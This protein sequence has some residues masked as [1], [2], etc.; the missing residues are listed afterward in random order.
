MERLKFTPIVERAKKVGDLVRKHGKEIVVGGLIIAG[1]TVAGGV[2]VD[3]LNRLSVAEKKIDVLTGEALAAK[4]L[5]HAHV[6]SFCNLAEEVGAVPPYIDCEK[7]ADQVIFS[8]DQAAEEYTK[9]L[10]K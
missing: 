10:T 6:E 7:L 5:D 1:N 4:E 8:R 3:A 9:E 2:A